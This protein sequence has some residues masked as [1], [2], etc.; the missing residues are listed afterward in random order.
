MEKRT[1]TGARVLPLV[2]T[3]TR[4]ALEKEIDGEIRTSKSRIKIVIFSNKLK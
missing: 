1:S 2:A 4:L 3:E